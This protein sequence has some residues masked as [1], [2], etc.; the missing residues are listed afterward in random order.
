L[1]IAHLSIAILFG[2]AACAGD[3]QGAT[4]VKMH[5]SAFNAPVVRIP[6]GAGVTFTNVGRIAHNVVPVDPA[7]WP[8]GFDTSAVAPGGALRV[9]LEASGV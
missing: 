1:R 7:R 9:A 8:A 5:D 3:P 4:Q 6:A 2:A